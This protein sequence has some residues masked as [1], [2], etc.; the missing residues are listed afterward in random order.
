MSET[1]Q[2]TA[3]SRV[4]PALAKETASGSGCAFVWTA[5]PPRVCERDYNNKINKGHP[6]T[7][8]RRVTNT[9]TGQ[10]PAPD[11]APS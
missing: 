7:V 6:S 10:P 5:E 9:I 11:A 4:P 2:I 8:A 3:S 1:R